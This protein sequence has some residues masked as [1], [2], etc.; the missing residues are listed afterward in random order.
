MD[1][2]YCFYRSWI[3]HIPKRFVSDSISYSPFDGDS[4]IRVHHH[5]IPEMWK[6]EKNLLKINTA[7]INTVVNSQVRKNLV[8]GEY[9]FYVLSLFLY[10]EIYNGIS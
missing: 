5:N 4:P 6:V 9:F 10:S 1:A 7:I 3:N 8:G 2:E